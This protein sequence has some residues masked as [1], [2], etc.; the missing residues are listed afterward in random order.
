MATCSDLGNN[1]ENG[2]VVYSNATVT[3][4]RYSQDTTATVSCFE[5]YSGGGVITCLD[6]GNWSYPD[7]P[8]CESECAPAILDG[9]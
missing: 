6:T 5:G 9:N 1:V 2:D 3:E 7:L 8:I 4:G